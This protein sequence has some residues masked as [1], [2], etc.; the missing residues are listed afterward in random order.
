MGSADVSPPELPIEVHDPVVLTAVFIVAEELGLA[1]DIAGAARLME[2]IGRRPGLEL[3]EALVGGMLKS[4]D[5]VSLLLEIE[6]TIFARTGRQITLSD[7]RAM[8]AHK[9]PFRDAAT[10]TDYVVV[11]L[12]G[13]TK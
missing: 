1:G 8:A 13:A 9:N 7:E 12:A 11:L 2:A 3:L 5:L 4:F 6:D 10:L